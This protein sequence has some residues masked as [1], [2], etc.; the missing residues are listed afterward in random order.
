MCVVACEVA[1]ALWY[2]CFAV[3]AVPVVVVYDVGWFLFLTLVVAA[4][5]SVSEVVVA[6]C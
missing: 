3:H 5:L 2:L 4:P 6:A 1:F